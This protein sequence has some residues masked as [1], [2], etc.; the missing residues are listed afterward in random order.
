MTKIS[1]GSAICALCHEALRPDEDAVV[2]PDFLA[3]DT[4]AFYPYSDAAMHRACLVVWDRRKA[5]IAHFNRI[6]ERFT[7]EGGSR[8]QMTSEGDLV[9]RHDGP[10]PP[11]PTAH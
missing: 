5:F 3:D 6:A 9:E 8:V 10:P 4:D 1:A 2:T 7:A 11:G